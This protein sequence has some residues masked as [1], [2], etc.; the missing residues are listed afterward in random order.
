M[1]KNAADEQGLKWQK[2]DD[3]YS[4]EMETV[5]SSDPAFNIGED[6]NGAMGKEQPKA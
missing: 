1:D 3:E 4:F 6:D 2:A 5:A